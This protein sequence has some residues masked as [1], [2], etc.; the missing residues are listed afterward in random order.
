MSIYLCRKVKM[1]LTLD[2]SVLEQLSVKALL[3]TLNNHFERIETLAIETDVATS[4]P[5]ALD[6]LG[7]GSEFYRPV[8]SIL[9]RLVLR[10]NADDSIL[11]PLPSYLPR[12][13]LISALPLHQA[14]TTLYIDGRNLL[15]MLRSSKSGRSGRPGSEMVFS[16]TPKLETI[17]INHL[18]RCVDG[19][20]EEL[21][22]YFFIVILPSFQH[23]TT[24]ALES[25][26]FEQPQYPD[27]LSYDDL[28]VTLSTVPE[29]LVSLSLPCLVLKYTSR[30]SIGFVLRCIRRPHTIVLDGCFL[31]SPTPP[32]SSLPELFLSCSKLVLANI[33]SDFD[34]SLPGLISQWDGEYLE[35][36]SCPCIDDDFW[37]N[38]VTLLSSLTRNSKPGSEED[39]H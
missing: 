4:L 34:R 12:Q 35:L 17:G 10:C 25:I 24:L 11:Q 1:P 36:I 21:I 29:P 31:S 33:P 14:L 32:P 6:L 13:P 5:N 37:C 39:G 27:L 2:V 3:N 22:H 15:E 26:D 30:E 8:Q 38:M 18:T 9:R 23:L 7:N 16:C 20:S 19:F 28:E